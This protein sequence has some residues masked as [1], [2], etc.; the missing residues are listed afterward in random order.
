[1]EIPSP[2]EL[3]ISRT[4][5]ACPATCSPQRP[6][7]CLWCMDRPFV[8]HKRTAIASVAGSRQ[9]QEVIVSPGCLALRGVGLAN[10]VAAASLALHILPMPR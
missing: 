10:V 2:R 8:I 1:M 9:W 4:G 5:A 6:A 7:A 3:G